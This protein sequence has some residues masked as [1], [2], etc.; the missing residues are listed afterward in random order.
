MYRRLNSFAIRLL[1]RW[2][3]EQIIGSWD[4]NGLKKYFANTGW[5]L[6]G[7]ILTFIIS[8]FTIAFVARYLGPE[9]L[10]KLSY[11]QSFVAI[12]SMFASLGIDQIVYRDL[13]SHPEREGEILGTAIVTKFIFGIA[14]FVLTVS[15]GYLINDEPLLTWLIAL[16]ALTF[17]LQPVGTVG[18]VFGARVLSKYTTL[19]SL[20]IAIVIPIL[21]LLIISLDQGILYFAVIVA[22]EGLLNSLCNYA[23]Y[24]YILSRSWRTW[25]IRFATFR[26]LIIDA[27]PLMFVGITGYLYVRIDQVMLLHY[28]D[29]TTVGLYEA[30]VRLTDPL[31]FLPGIVMGSLFPA[32]I[33]ARKSNLFEYRRRLRSLAILSLST[34]GTL[35]LLMF[36]AAPYLIGILYGPAFSDSVLIL[37]IYVWS[38]V[39]TIATMLM[40]N[41]F[42]AEGKTYL[43]LMYTALGAFTNVILNFLLIPLWGAPGAAVATLLTV[44]MIIASFLLTKRLRQ[45]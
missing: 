14:T 12:F 45:S 31:G 36:I 25:Q 43:Q 33:N 20:F 27:W 1:P 42:I 23:L 15:V 34:S 7:R 40:Y 22:V 5:M 44:I 11:A 29:S 9:N 38:T 35:A 17:I 13:V 39:G 3:Y 30:A 32:L 10:G 26:S 28:I 18:H 6:L 2:L 37:R 8:F 16:C 41:Y 24:R 21:K 4:P 19:S